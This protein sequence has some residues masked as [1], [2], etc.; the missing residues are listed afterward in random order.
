[1]DFGTTYSSIAYLFTAV[2]EPEPIVVTEWPGA[3][4]AT[5]PKAPTLIQYDKP[6]TKSFTWG[7]ELAH[8]NSGAKIQAIK[9]LLDPD[10][11]KPLYVPQ[12]NTKAELQRLGKP[13]VDVVADY[14]AAIYNH[15]VSK[16]EEAWPED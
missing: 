4:G 5:K 14:L 8:L 6:P 2:E 1:M 10:Q 13:P 7:Y 11:P 12:S 16:I 9:L 15:A 3:K